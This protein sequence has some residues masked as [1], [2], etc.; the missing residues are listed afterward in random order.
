LL[1]S[2]Y[3]DTRGAAAYLACSTSYLE[4]CRVSGRGPRFI[5][6]GKAVRYKIEDLDAW[7]NSRAH[8]STSEYPARAP[9]PVEAPAEPAARPGK[10]IS[11]FLPLI[12]AP[13]AQAG[14]E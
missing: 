2:N 9:A 14:N 8:G 10:R 4:K 12:T 11:D 6:I 13:L 3:I 5:K 1:A 7:A